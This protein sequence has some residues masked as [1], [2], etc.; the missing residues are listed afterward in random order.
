[1]HSKLLEPSSTDFVG[2]IV[3]QQAC[4]RT[5]HKSGYP[6]DAPNLHVLHSPQPCYVHGVI[7]QCFVYFD[8]TRYETWKFIS[9]LAPFLPNGALWNLWFSPISRL[10]CSF[11]RSVISRWVINLTI[12]CVAKQES[13]YRDDT[14]TDDFF[15]LGLKNSD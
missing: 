4:C 7:Y 14:R 11:F 1:M 15:S 3:L 9:L 5:C 10:L 12:L 2:S 13:I 6:M 8:G